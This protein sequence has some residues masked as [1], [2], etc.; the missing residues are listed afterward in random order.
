MKY[1]PVLASLVLILVPTS[2]ASVAATDCQFGRVQGFVAVRGNPQYL[3][4]TIPTRFTSASRFFSRRYNCMHHSAAIR[5]VD[6]GTYDVFFPGLRGRAVFAS[7]NSDDGVAASSEQIGP[8]VYRVVL[9]GP[10]LANNI[11][12]LRDVPFSL[13]VF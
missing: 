8:G 3:V 4:G 9:R 1:L 6:L 11:L 2:H 7:A 12:A 5:R 10:Y 13:A